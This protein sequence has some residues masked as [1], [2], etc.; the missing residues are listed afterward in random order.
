MS[1]E[2]HIVK[3]SLVRILPSHTL[4]V[5]SKIDYEFLIYYYENTPISFLISFSFKYI[6]TVSIIAHAANKDGLY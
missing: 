1:Y 3:L 5:N 4:S 2:S 6:F